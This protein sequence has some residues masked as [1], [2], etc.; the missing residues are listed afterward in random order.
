MADKPYTRGER[1]EMNLRS[2]AWDALGADGIDR[3]YRAIAGPRRMFPRLPP[4]WV[5]RP[6]VPERL[7]IKRQHLAYRLCAALFV[8]EELAVR[9]SDLPPEMRGLFEK[10]YEMLRDNPAELWEL[11]REKG[12]PTPASGRLS[13]LPHPQSDGG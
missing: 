12:R 2:L 9:D 7:R 13:P 6:S 8:G 1:G 11:A 5:G 3:V 10:F 4:S